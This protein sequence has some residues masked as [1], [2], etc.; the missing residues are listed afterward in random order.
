VREAARGISGVPVTAA[1][2]GLGKAVES[3]LQG[4]VKGAI[5]K[6]SGYQ[7]LQDQARDRLGGLVEDDGLQP[8]R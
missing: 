5:E 4:P 3:G 2:K 8:R 7:G 6:G 1:R